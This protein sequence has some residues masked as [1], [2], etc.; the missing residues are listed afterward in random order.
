[1]DPIIK[2]YPRIDLTNDLYLAREPGIA[3]QKDMSNSVSYDESYFE[4]YVNLEG[5]EVAVKLNASRAKMVQDCDCVLDIGIGSGEFMRSCGKRCY[6]FDI[7]E[8]AVAKL[9]ETD[10]FIDPFEGIPESIDCITLWDAMEHM[11]CPSDL[12]LKP[13]VGVKVCVSLPIFDDLT[14]VTSSKHYKPDEHYYYYSPPGLI[15]FFEDMGYTLVDFNHGE[16]D[17]GRQGIGAFSFRRTK[18]LAL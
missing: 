2:C 9:K 10:S 15:R 5:K 1:M 4:N 18:M 12:M 13:R 3:Y 8:V 16:V 6:G 7:N 14:T 17:A 11:K